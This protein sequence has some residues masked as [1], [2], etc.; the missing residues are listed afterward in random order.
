MSV[1]VEKPGRC[2]A[3]ADALELMEQLEAQIS[4]KQDND[5]AW[6]MNTVRYVLARDIPVEPTLHDGKTWKYYYTCGRCGARIKTGMRFCGG[7]GQR[8]NDDYLGR[9]KT[10][11]EQLECASE[12]TRQA[13]EDVAKSAAQDQGSRIIDLVEFLKE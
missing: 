12:A 7:C 11:A 4:P 9:R 5:I 8:C 2:M 13:V 1:L 10:K 3:P 6:A